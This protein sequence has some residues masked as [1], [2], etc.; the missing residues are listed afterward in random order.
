MA[1]IVILSKELKIA[2]RSQHEAASQIAAKL[3][4]L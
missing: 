1:I 4:S 3:R 2:R